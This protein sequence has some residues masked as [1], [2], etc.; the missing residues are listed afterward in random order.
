MRQALDEREANRTASYRSA[1]DH[2]ALVINQVI[3]DV[4]NLRTEKQ[5]K[6]LLGEI[7]DYRRDIR[8]LISQAD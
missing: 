4:L 1:Y 2:N 8:K 3:A 6:R 5:S 7:A